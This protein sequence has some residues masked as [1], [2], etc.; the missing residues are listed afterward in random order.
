L[1]DPSSSSDK[2]S[3]NF[4]RVT[5]SLSENFSINLSVTVRL[6][7]IDIWFVGIFISGETTLFDNIFQLNRINLI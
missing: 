7:K 4:V 1:G 5:K 6:V 2:D 3:S